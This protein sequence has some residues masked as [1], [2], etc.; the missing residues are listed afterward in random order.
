MF[1]GSQV[2]FPWLVCWLSM[3]EKFCLRNE[4]PNCW[5]L[6]WKLYQNRR[7]LPRCR[8]PLSTNRAL[9]HRGKSLQKKSL[10]TR[11]P[12]HL[13]DVPDNYKMQVSPTINKVLYPEHNIDGCRAAKEP[14]HELGHNLCY[15]YPRWPP[16]ITIGKVKKLK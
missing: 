1:C 14:Y 2:W 9:N 6:L 10:W 5:D 3:K 15:I 4:I 13:I 11:Y 16:G 12:W 8:W 7:I